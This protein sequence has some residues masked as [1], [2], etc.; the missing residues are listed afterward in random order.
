M[1]VGSDGIVLIDT[2]MIPECAER[3]LAR[4]REITDLPIRSIIYTH[5]HGDHTG[6]SP[7]FCAEGSRPEIWARDNFGIEAEPFVRAGLMPLFKARGA[8]QGG[9]LLPPDKRICNGIAPVRYPRAKGAVFAG[10]TGGSSFFIFTSTMRLKWS[11][12]TGHDRNHWDG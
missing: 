11:G 10:K 3:T 6:G 8:K 4:F 2:G 7:V 5:G 1:I 9:F 12:H